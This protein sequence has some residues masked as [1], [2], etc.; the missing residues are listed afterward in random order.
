M[1]DESSTH[2]QRFESILIIFKVVC[3]LFA[4]SI[5]TRATEKSDDSFI[6][7]LSQYAATLK[8]I[9]GRDAFDHEMK[10]LRALEGLQNTVLLKVVKQIN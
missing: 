4:N 1:K 6:L 7:M 8:I 9:K 2:Q 3:R 5:T 10:W